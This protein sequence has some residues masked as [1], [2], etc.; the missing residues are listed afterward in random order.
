LSLYI[1]VLK[2]PSWLT[3]RFTSD[4]AVK[5]LS[6]YLKTNSIETVCVTSRCPNICE[7]FSDGNVSFL[8]LGNVCTRNCL[9][10]AIHAGRPRH[11]NTAEISAIANSVC[12]LNL[13]Y[14]VITSVTR[15]DIPDGGASHYANV[16]KAIKDI[17]PKTVIETLIPD[18]KGSKESI[19]KVIDAGVDVFSHNMETVA[20]LYPH[21]RPNFD[22][23]RSLDVLRYA[24]SL[25]KAVIKS[26]F[27]LG[28]GE[29]AS[30]INQLMH[31]IRDTGC[32]FLTIGQY[33][34][35]KD[36]PLEVK[37][38]VPPVVFKELKDKA[39][40]MGFIEVAS[41]PF[42]RSSYKAVEYFQVV[43]N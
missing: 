41:G 43:R 13:K 6:D 40:K 29:N 33:L 8:I 27:M 7:C 10:C 22:Y 35:P 9:F 3:K 31:D 42:V 17:S 37:S 16:V 23:S 19:D 5:E 26:G 12:R 24:S 25:N 21:V 34:R 32:S 14:V 18:F 15:D 30:E 2:K 1:N 4:E 28:L 36:S 38:Y 20:K 39:L 11:I